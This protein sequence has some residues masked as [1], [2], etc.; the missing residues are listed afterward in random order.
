MNPLR[1][2]TAGP[3]APGHRPVLVFIN[4]K[5]GPQQGSA[6]RRK[7]LRLLNPL[8]VHPPDACTY[9]RAM[10][11]P[12][13]YFALSIAELS[14]YS[15]FNRSSLYPWHDCRIMSRLYSVAH[16][17]AEI[18]W[19]CQARH[20][21]TLEIYILG[22]TTVSD[23]TALHLLI[24]PC[25]LLL[26]PTVVPPHEKPVLRSTQINPSLYMHPKPCL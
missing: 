7:F 10:H 4:T 5:S 21:C 24:K 12:G 6:L 16:E 2:C 25:Q 23:P 9:L 3:V 20:S 11:S 17:V 14:V 18:W 13:K 1:P 26:W 22:S 19:W 8:Q 15:S